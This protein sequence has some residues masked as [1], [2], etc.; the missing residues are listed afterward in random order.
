MNIIKKNDKPIADLLKEFVKKSEPVK[1]AFAV[2]N[3]EAIF[4]EKMGPVVASYTR[5][6][7]LRGRVLYVNIVSA[8]LKAE[9]QHSKISLIQ[10]MNESLGEDIIQ[11]IVFT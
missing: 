2:M 9:L 5:K 7:Y 1:K 8:P 10:L 3:I 4:I 11:E 6:I